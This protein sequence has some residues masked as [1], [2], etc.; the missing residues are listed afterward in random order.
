MK[1]SCLCGAVEYEVDQLDTPIQ[2]C[3]CRT[4]QK[5]HSAAFNSASGVLRDHF[6]W[7]KGED[8]LSS[9]ESSPGKLRYFCST[10]GSHLVADKEGLPWLVLRVAS[11]DEDPGAR[12]EFR[13]W[14]SQES[15]WLDYGP[16]LH[17]YPESKPKV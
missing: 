10:C 12:P 9:Y 2:H 7:V 5:A 17:R 4:C 3:S 16:H 8:R 14:T 1:G 15:A 11:L 6:R 13:I